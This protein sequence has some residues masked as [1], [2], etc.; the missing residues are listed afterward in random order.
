MPY[1]VTSVDP[2][3]DVSQR[4]SNSG[5]RSSSEARCNASGGAYNK[6]GRPTYKIF[7][8]I[9]LIYSEWGA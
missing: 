3:V 7:I 2:E 9:G 1:V 8:D 5:A 6:E 4:F